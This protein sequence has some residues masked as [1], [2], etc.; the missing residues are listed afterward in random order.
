MPA[1][2]SDFRF[3]SRCYHSI[4][5]CP[6]PPLSPLNCN[7]KS[8]PFIHPQEF[9]MDLLQFVLDLRPEAAGLLGV[10]KELHLK[11]KDTTVLKRCKLKGS[12]YIYDAC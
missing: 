4:L 9:Q 5:G 6:F 2:F 3:P 1:N 11:A 7:N 10:E 12:M 8:D